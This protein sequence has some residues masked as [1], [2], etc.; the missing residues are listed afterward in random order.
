M[1]R[2]ADLTGLSQYPV[3][4][5]QAAADSLHILRFCPPLTARR[6]FGGKEIQY[7]VADR[8]STGSLDF[9]RRPRSAGPELLETKNASRI[10]AGG[11]SAEPCRRVAAWCRYGCHS[12]DSLVFNM[13]SNTS[14]MLFGAVRYCTSGARRRATAAILA[15]RIYP[16]AGRGHRGNRRTASGSTARLTAA[17]RGG[18]TGVCLPGVLALPRACASSY[19]RPRPRTPRRS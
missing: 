8:L 6:A 18:R 7:A 4:K 3:F 17:A 2:N 1:V 19:T 12:R 16:E 14:A 11:A 15:R 10:H 13:R 5:V 9:S